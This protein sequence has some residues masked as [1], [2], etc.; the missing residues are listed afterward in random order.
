MT[1]TELSPEAVRA[2]LA[3][4]VE[5]H[6]LVRVHGGAWDRKELLPFLPVA[7]SRGILFSASNGSRIIGVMI[8]GPT[9][10]PTGRDNFCAEG[11]LLFCYAWLVDPKYREQAILHDINK[12]LKA[13]AY[14]AFPNTEK[15]VYH[16]FD[17]YVEHRIRRKGDE[18]CASEDQA[19][20]TSEKVETEPS[21]NLRKVM[22]DPSGVSR[23]LQSSTSS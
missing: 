1:G 12:T 9:N 15:F 10:K 11:R 5:I 18:P 19:P 2:Y 13:Q 3:D 7:A 20:G 22:R 21:S 16:H 14:A 4:F 8:A 6:E 17:K 23:W